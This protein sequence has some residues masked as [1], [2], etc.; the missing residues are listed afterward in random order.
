MEATVSEVD[1]A[2]LEQFL[3]QAVTDMGAAMNGVSGDAGRQARALEGD[4][5][6]RAADGGR[7]RRA[8]GLAER[9][10]REWA[11]RPGRERLRRLRRGARDLRAPARAGDG[12]RRRGQPGLPARRLPADRLGLQGPRRSSRS[13]SDRATAS[14]GTST[15]RSS[16]CGTEQFF[17]PGYRAAP[18]RRVDPG[19]RR[20]RGQ[21]ASAAARSPTS[22][23]ATGSR[24]C[25]WPRR[26]PRVD[27]LRL[28]LPRRVDRAGDGDRRGRAWPTNTR[29]RG[30]EREG[31]SRRA[32]TTW[33]ASSTACTTWAT[34]SA[35]LRAR[36]RRDR[37]RRHGDAGR[38]V[39]RRLAGR[40]PQP[41][42]ADLL[43]R[44]DRDLHA[45]VARPGGRPGAG[46]PGRRGSGCARSPSEAGFTRF[47]RAT[48]TPF[49]LVLEAR[50]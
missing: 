24:P 34:R 25:S 8:H 10:V 13:G 5:G 4:G 31:L 43:R 40:E 47:R 14:A 44:L 19:A 1:E 38:A 18:G 15:T 50:P 37:G 16:S 9:Y 2:R 21:A 28:R 49:N 27:L 29:V 35:P 36:P 30:G 32:A 48:E 46:R 26:I 3:G 12:V 6:R 23:A 22:A 39:R 17:R 11:V 20:R 41:G 42:R 45:V 33:S 7:D